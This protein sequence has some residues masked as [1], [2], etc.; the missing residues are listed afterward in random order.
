MRAARS[1]DAALIVA[2]LLIGTVYLRKFVQFHDEGLVLQAAERMRDGDWPYRDFW[3]NYGPGQPLLLAGLAEAFGP[4]LLGWRLVRLAT[5]AVVA[6]LAFR[7]ARRQ[8]SLAPS[9]AVWVATL[10]ATVIVRLPHPHPT[11]ALL[12]LASVLLAARRPAT[13][14]VAAGLVALFRPELALPAIA[15]VA[16]A[17][18]RTGAAK[19]AGVATATGLVALA[20]FSI[21]AGFDEPWRSTF[22]FSIGIQGRTRILPQLDFPG[23]GPFDALNFY[24]P[25]LLLVGCALVA[26]AATRWVP[27][28]ELLAL[29]PMTAAGAAYLA[30]RADLYHLIPL[31]SVL[32]VLLAGAAAGTWEK[33]RP[34]SVALAMVLA[35]VIA[36]GVDRRIDVLTDDPEVARLDSE[37]ADGVRIQPSEAEPLERVVSLVRRLTPPGEPVYV[38]NPRHDLIANGNSL[39]YVLL[40]RPNATRYDVMQSGV[41]T[42]REV[43]EE[44]VRHLREHQPVVVRWLSEGA[45][46]QED[47]A[48]GSSSGVRLLDRHLAEAYRPVRRF[49]DYRVLEPLGR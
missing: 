11:V 28:R 14:G 20:P 49:G 12:T 21:A 42:S 29:L 1:L 38:A 41:Q 19:A 2:G 35:L 17:A 15:G 36:D 33:A 47:N 22:G 13:A 4:S 24:L 46:S 9:L 39:L 40:Q 3:W 32:P 8:L 25:V 45:I 43:Q 27:E 6:L 7:L 48:S 37:I 44:I 31:V 34:L 5:D 23:G 18:G 26:I 16:I 30:G 10:L